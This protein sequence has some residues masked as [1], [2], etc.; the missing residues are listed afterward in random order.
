MR[1]PNKKTNRATDKE[2]GPKSENT[3]ITI[4]C[5][6]VIFSTKNIRLFRINKYDPMQQTIQPIIINNSMALFP[7]NFYSL[8]Q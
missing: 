3:A 5:V 8:G 1:K 2:I 7:C 6:K 4:I